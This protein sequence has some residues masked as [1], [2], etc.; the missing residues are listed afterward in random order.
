MHKGFTFIA[1]HYKKIF[2]MD[3][4]LWVSNYLEQI[5]CQGKESLLRPKEN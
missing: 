5:L 4:L 2:P 1:S 3:F